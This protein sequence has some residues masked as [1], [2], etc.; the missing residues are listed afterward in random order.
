MVQ[1]RNSGSLLEAGEV[2]Q[3]QDMEWVPGGEFAMGSDRNYP[4]E[5]P[6]HRVAVDG[7]WMDRHTVTNRQFEKFVHSTS[8][9][10]LAERYAS[11]AD[12]PDAS[13]EMLSPASPC[14]QRRCALAG[15]GA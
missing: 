2:S 3:P 11:A 9:V 8:H 1:T 10:T 4:E 12:H 6:V 7:F 5:V 15:R 13:P 14:G